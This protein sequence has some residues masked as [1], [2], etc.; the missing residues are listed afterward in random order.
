MAVL[1]SFSVTTSACEKGGD[2]SPSREEPRAGARAYE[3]L[4]VL[5]RAYN[6]FSP[7]YRNLPERLGRAAVR[8][9]EDGGIGLVALQEASLSDAPVNK[10]ACPRPESSRRD[11]VECFRDLVRETNPGTDPRGVRW[12]G[13]GFVWDDYRWENIGWEPPDSTSFQ[14]L[15]FRVWNLPPRIRQNWFQRL[16]GLESHDGQYMIGVRFRHRSTGR[17]LRL[18][19]THFA[20]DSDGD[21]GKNR[22]QRE[23]QAESVVRILDSQTFL[24]GE[25]PPI[26]LGDLNYKPAEQPAPA[27]ILKR[28]F[29]PMNELAP[30]G[31]D[32]VMQVWV[33]KTGVFPRT[34]GRYDLTKY[35]LPDMGPHPCGDK[36][37]PRCITDHQSPSL[38]FDP[39]G[40][41]AQTDWLFDA[42]LDGTPDGTSVV[43]GDPSIVPV[44]GRWKRGE[45]TGISAF[46][47][48]RAEWAFDTNRDGTVDGNR[49]RFGDPSDLPLSGDWDGDGTDGIAVL[50][51]SNGKLYID[52]NRD[53]SVD[54][55]LRKVAAFG[56]LLSGD[57]PV[58]GDWNGDGRDG[59]AIFRPSSTR[60]Y[61][62]DSFDGR[63]DRK[64]MYGRTGD[65][66]VTGDWDGNGR[67]GIGV[68]R[69]GEWLLDDG[70][71]A[72]VDRNVRFGGPESF[73]VVGEATGGRRRGGLGTVRPRTAIEGTV[74][75][76]VDVT[77]GGT[78]GASAPGV[79]CEPV[80]P[81]TQRCE[82]KFPYES[83]VEIFPIGE[84]TRNWGG[85]CAGTPDGA[86]CNVL[87]TRPRR[88]TVDML[89]YG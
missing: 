55:P 33:A 19:D 10:I 42:N 53:G 52:N 17:V 44:S 84:Q 11:I 8:F 77:G 86:S 65:T 72:G 50:R 23:R 16:F 83:E 54:A 79:R 27:E 63:V 39:Q 67:D 36:E 29:S 74:P 20:A 1:A 68:F 25:L 34:S 48:P 12:G 60:W 88:A 13:L 4:R 71:D 18:L 62:D 28:R 89:Q 3:D 14:S 6:V 40:N 76:T 22:V 81:S 59:V 49:L 43:F 61:I 15:P 80:G 35:T 69:R 38:A 31:D 57:Q 85:D 37:R 73:P 45:R 32:A 78:V 82:G 46:I 41:T 56:G 64:L 70:L 30:E 5:V 26:L 87:M 24:P 47:P 58:S 75:L 51:P 66:P 9:R 2:G 7:G 21:D